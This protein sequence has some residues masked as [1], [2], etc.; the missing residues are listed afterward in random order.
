MVSQRLKTGKTFP[1][2]TLSGLLYEIIGMQDEPKNKITVKL[3]SLVGVF[4]HEKHRKERLDDLA[5][6]KKAKNAGK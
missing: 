1:F 2:E 3:A 4:L 5:A 6:E